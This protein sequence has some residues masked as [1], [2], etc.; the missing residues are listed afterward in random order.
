MAEPPSRSIRAS[1][2]AVHGFRLQ[3]Y[4][5]NLVKVRDGSMTFEEL[6]QDMQDKC[7]QYA[8]DKGLTFYKLSDTC[9]QPVLMRA[10]ASKK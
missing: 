7:V 6:M 1:A 8:K 2:G 5:D 3:T 10:P 4:A 9:G